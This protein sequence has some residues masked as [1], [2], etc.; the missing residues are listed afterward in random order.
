M[1]GCIPNCRTSWWNAGKQGKGEVCQVFWDGFPFSVFPKYFSYLICMPMEEEG[2][3]PKD[4]FDCVYSIYGI[5]RTTDLP[6]TFKKI[7][8]YV[9]A[10]SEAGFVIEKS[11]SPS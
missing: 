7:A 10:L 6:G 3:I 11:V 5:G 1:L 8:S 9:N 4:Y 2:D